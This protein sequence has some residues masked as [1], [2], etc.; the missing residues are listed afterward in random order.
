MSKV[1]DVSKV[2]QA[3]DRAARNAQRGSSDVRAGKYLAGRNA[4]SGQY[5]ARRESNGGK[6]AR[7]DKK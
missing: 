5:V 6:Q 7:G 4:E 2:Q 3:L 1:V